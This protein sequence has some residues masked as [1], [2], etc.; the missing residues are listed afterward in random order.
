MMRPVLGV[1]SFWLMVWPL[2]AENATNAAAPI[3]PVGGVVDST[4]DPGAESRAQIPGLYQAW[5]A[6]SDPTKRAQ[7]AGQL[8]DAVIHCYQNQPTA[9]ADEVARGGLPQREFIFSGAPDEVKLWPIQMLGEAH[10]GDDSYPPGVVFRRMTRS[11]FEA[12]TARE[13][14]LFNTKG[15]M[16]ADAHVPRRDGTGSEWYGAFLPD[17]TWITTD[18][19]ENDEQLN[20][21]SAD[22]HWRWELTGKAMLARLPKPKE[23]PDEAP[24]DAQI[25]SSIGWARCDKTGARWLVC[26]GRD[27]NRINAF[28]S[29]HRG[30][31]PEPKGRSMWS[32]V[33][34]RAMGV[35]GFYI[36]LGIDSDDGKASL[37][38][39]E[40]GHGV[41]V[42]WP[43]YQ[44]TEGGWSGVVYGGTNEFGFWP[45]THD[46]YLHAG[47]ENTRAPGRTWFFDRTGRYL[48]ET[49]GTYLG[50]VSN[51]RDIELNA[52][53]NRVETLRRTAG[54][55]EISQARD[56][57]WTDGAPALPLAIYEDIRLG[58]FLRGPDIA[59]ETDDARRARAKAEVVLATW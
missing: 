16:L 30:S 23:N 34:P 41:E 32:E 27:G 55:V 6:E 13:G 24:E 1:I 40:A 33:Y 57:T 36:F 28:V 10:A 17:G 58:F 49:V 25:A 14:W 45:G 50:D 21:F 59:G 7:L 39:N 54:S 2:T 38:R 8:V 43:Y 15:K 5:K 4:A 46:F 51:G 3:S 56:F 26:L 31:V 53:D 12:W 42:G 48:G 35:R 19:W 52:G 37:S 44:M 11:R 29:P 9:I 22:G 18:L 47:E 20:C